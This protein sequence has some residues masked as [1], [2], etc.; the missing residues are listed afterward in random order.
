MNIEASLDER[1]GRIHRDAL[2]AAWP[3]MRDHESELLFSPARCGLYSRRFSRGGY[4]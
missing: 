4:V 3:E 2:R 1:V